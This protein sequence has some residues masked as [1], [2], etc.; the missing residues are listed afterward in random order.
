ME[1]TNTLLLNVSPASQDKTHSWHR[2]QGEKPTTK[3]FMWTRGDPTTNILL[4]GSIN[5]KRISR[6]LLL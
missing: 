2:Y 6:V 3:E 1:V 5:I 4:I